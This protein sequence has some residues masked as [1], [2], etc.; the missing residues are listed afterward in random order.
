MQFLILH[1]NCASEL[2]ILIKMFE[3]TRP[4]LLLCF[5]NAPGS[6]FCVLQRGSSSEYILSIIG[7]FG[8][9]IRIDKD[10]EV[11]MDAVELASE[12][13]FQEISTYKPSDE[14][15][16]D[17]SHSESDAGSTSHE[18]RR[19]SSTTQQDYQADEVRPTRAPGLFRR[20]AHRFAR[21][22]RGFR[23]W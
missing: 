15:E 21:K 20:I 14:S 6:P 2:L 12:I 3:N 22:F 9:K 8:E 11:A 23:G 13:I 7:T 18:E 16:E 5:W 10:E 17:D 19:Q 4:Q 1:L